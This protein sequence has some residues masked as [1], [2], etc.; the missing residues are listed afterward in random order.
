VTIDANKCPTIKVA[1]KLQVCP[2]KS[3][4]VFAVFLDNYLEKRIAMSYLLGQRYG[5]IAHIVGPLD[6]WESRQWIADWKDKLREPVP[7]AREGHY[8]EGKWSSADHGVVGFDNIPKLTFYHPATTTMQQDQY[9]VGKIAVPC[10]R[11]TNKQ[12]GGEGI[13][14]KKRSQNREALA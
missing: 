9:A 2:H 4:L 10:A 11:L 1:V 6:W 8:T 3:Y 7:E 5:H 14:G 13:K 12:E